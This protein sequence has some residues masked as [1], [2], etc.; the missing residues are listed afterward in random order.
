MLRPYFAVGKFLLAAPLTQLCWIACAP[1]VSA[2]LNYTALFE[3]PLMMHPHLYK[4]ACPL[5]GWLVGPSVRNAFVKID[6]KWTFT[7]FK[8]FG[9]G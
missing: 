3:L 4:R 5:V 7:D 1:A 2:A 8:R 6:E 9:A